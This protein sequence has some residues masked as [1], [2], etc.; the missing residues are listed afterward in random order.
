MRTRASVTQST[1][2]PTLTGL[3]SNTGICSDRKKST[4]YGPWRCK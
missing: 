2:N 4:N 1:K 3:G